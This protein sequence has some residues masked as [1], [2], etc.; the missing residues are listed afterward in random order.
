MLVFMLSAGGLVAEVLARESDLPG[1]QRY[2]A[3]AR[4]RDPAAVPGTAPSSPGDD[5]ARATVASERFEAPVERIAMPAIGVTAPLVPM[6]VRNGYMDLPASPHEVAWYDFTAKPGTGG[7]AVFSAH[8]DYINYGPAVFWN[9]GKLKLGDDVLIRLRDGTILR[10]VVTSN[11][12]VPLPQL[13]V[14]QLLAQRPR[15]TVTLITCT[16]QFSNGNYSHRIVVRAVLDSVVRG[17]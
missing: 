14:A 5:V 16:G 7:N 6:G 9:L 1:D 17:S 12:T 3:V 2:G 8:V 10:Y 11:D 4:V 15:E 13:D